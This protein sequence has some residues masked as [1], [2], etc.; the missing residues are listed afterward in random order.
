[1]G[2]DFALPSGKKKKQHINDTS[3]HTTL[4][5]GQ[6]RHK[7]SSL[8]AMT[9]SH[10]QILLKDRSTVTQACAHYRKREKDS[11]KASEE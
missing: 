2:R 7:F 11:Q 8:Y 6:S 1:M 9:K 5:K 10:T 4:E 3:F